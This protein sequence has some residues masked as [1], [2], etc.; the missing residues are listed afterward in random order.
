MTS[1]AL[2]NQIAAIILDVHSHLYTKEE[3]FDKITEAIKQQDGVIKY[4]QPQYQ[5][6][7]L[8][9]KDGQQLEKEL[10]EFLI[11]LKD[12]GY[13]LDDVTYQSRLLPV[14]GNESMEEYSVLVIYKMLA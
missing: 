10:N 6:H 3:G 12:Q 8:T 5:S 9:A 2:I 13:E 14:E 4:K 1:N 7:L 11:Y